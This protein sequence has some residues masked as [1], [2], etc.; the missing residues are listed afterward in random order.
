MV[1]GA[2]D[3]HGRF[4]VSGNSF[5]QVNRFLFER[6]AE[7]AVAGLSGGHALDLYAGVGLFSMP[8][9]KA[10]EQ[11]TAVES[12]KAAVRD[13]EF[14]TARAELGNVRAVAGTTEGYLESLEAAPDAA[15]LDPPRAGLGKHVV[16]R[17]AELRPRTV[18]IVSCDPATLA[19]D[20]AGLVAAG[21]RIEAMTLVDLFPQTFHI[22][23]VVR[24]SL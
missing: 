22:E 13:L 2:L 16:R 20:L 6:L 15:L 17:L 5:F 3:Y 14:N 23:T 24:L 9:A 19:R 12:G 10:F 7:A 21:Y 11:V 1:D 8:L 4:R 18:S